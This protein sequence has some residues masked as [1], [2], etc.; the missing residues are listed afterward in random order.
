VPELV[1]TA[2][3]LALLAGIALAVAA[4]PPLVLLWVAAAVSGLGCLLGIPGGIA[5]HVT[6]RRELL[7]QGALP[8]GWLWH[9]SRLHDQLDDDANARIRPW[10][11]MGALGFMLIMLSAALVTVTMVT[12][13]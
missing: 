10:F 12:H 13:F 7:R 1:V 9:P 5:Y 11:L 2:L 3:G 4:L 6:L 8:R